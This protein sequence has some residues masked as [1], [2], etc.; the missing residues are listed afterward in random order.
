MKTLTT[1]FS[2]SLLMLASTNSF[3]D[4]VEIG[5]GDDGV[6]HYVDM[7]NSRVSNGDVYYWRMSDYLTPDKFGDMSA[8]VYSRGDCDV[9]R[10]KT[11]SYIFYKR[12]M[13]TGPSDQQESANKEWKYPAP[14]SAARAAL[15]IVCAYH[16]E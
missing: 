15:D 12:G 9:G 5:Q 2:V 1:L 14:N 8:Q 4:W 10:L 16:A 11:L 6:T 7:D 13:G 3:A